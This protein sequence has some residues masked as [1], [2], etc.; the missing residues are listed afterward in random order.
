[1]T[2]SQLID[3]IIENNASDMLVAVQFRD[4]GGYYQGGEL[5]GSDSVS[6]SPCLAHVKSD[7]A[8]AVDITYGGL[9]PNAIIL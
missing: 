4:G 6:G 7:S 3:W 8:G 2:G 1:M 5:V 9:T